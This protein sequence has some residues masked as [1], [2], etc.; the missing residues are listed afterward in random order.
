MFLIKCLNL[1]GR[2][3]FNLTNCLSLSL[4]FLRLKKYF[5]RFLSK[6]QKPENKVLI[7][8]YS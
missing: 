5:T 2:V 6:M 7:Q 1:A 8:K 3:F 4:V